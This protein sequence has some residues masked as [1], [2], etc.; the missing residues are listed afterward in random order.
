MG[1]TPP[2]G[3][4]FGWYDNYDLL[5]STPNGHRETHAMATEFQMHPAGIIN[6]R[7]KPGMST[8][9]FP[10]LTAQQAK[11]V[12]KNRASCTTATLTQKNSGI[13]YSEACARQAGLMA[14]QE[15]GAVAEHP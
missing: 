1:L 14:A 15:A 12:G 6:S 11:S 10:R 3:L 9:V 8:L 4:I 2:A 7:A 5:V 13:S